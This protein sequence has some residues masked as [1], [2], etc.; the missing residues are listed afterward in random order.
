VVW[1]LKYL[2]HGFHQNNHFSNTFFAILQMGMVEGKKE[3]V[4]TGQNH[5]LLMTKANP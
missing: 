1:R 2:L 3:I 4:Q 5:L